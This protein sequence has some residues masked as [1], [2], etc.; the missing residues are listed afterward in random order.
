MTPLIDTFSRTNDL[1][2]PERAG[3]GFR[4]AGEH[5]SFGLV[6]FLVA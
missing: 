2:N 3:D 5:P 6:R 1:A 4:V